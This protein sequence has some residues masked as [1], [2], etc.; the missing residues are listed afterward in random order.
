MVCYR[1]AVLA[2]DLKRKGYGSTC[3]YGLIYRVTDIKNRTETSE[4]V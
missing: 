3:R 2:G 1:D 4:Y